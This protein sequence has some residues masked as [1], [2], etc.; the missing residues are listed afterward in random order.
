MAEGAGLL[1]EALTA[2][3]AARTSRRRLVSC[4]LGGV[5]ST[6]VCCLA[7]GQEAK[8]VAYT[9]ASPDPLADDVA[10][11]A[12]TVAGLGNIEH[13][14][15]PADEMPLVYH[16]LLAM[17][18]SWMSHAASRDRDRWLTIVH[19]A[20]ARGSGLHLTG[21]GGDELLY[22]S[23]AHL[24]GLLRTNPRVALHHLRGFAAKY[25]W[26]RGEVL[27]QLSDPSPYQ[28]WLAGVADTLTVRGLLWMGRCWTGGSRPVCRLG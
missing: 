3:V 9:A 2:A 18:D 5:D 28:A 14:V 12:R 16:G 10:W 25:R 20:A 19:R 7:A 6:A 11:A 17:D 21:L 15:I 13:H 27:R 26:P 23:L 22:G 8:V 1:R 4:D 24:H